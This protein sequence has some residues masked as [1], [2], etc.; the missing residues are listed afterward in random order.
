MTELRRGL[1]L[2]ILFALGLVVGI[3]VFVAPWALGYPM[4]SGW[5]SSVWTSIWVGAALSG[6]SAAS[7]VALLARM[8]YTAQRREPGGD[9]LPTP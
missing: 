4:P 2:L 5:T 6:A 7:I 8:L 9:T 1:P 3:W